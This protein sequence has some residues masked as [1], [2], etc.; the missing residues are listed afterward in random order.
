[1]P[2]IMP[3]AKLPLQTLPS[4]SKQVTPQPL[5]TTQDV[6]T[7]PQK[8]IMPQKAVTQSK[9]VTSPPPQKPMTPSKIMMPQKPS[10]TSKV[11]PTITTTTKTMKPSMNGSSPLP[12]TLTKN[13]N[14]ADLIVMEKM[15][16]CSYATVKDNGSKK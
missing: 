10:S 11:T 7:T 4:K 6:T 1:M 12:V 2:V 13:S 14:K 5:K 16:N 9:V 3:Y 15:T 8:T